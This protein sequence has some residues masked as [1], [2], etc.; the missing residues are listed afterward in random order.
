MFSVQ[1][2]RVDELPSGKYLQGACNIIYNLWHFLV[3]LD[4]WYLLSLHLQYLWVSELLDV[5]CI[6][7]F[8]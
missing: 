3:Q 5:A 7:L 4:L 1:I 6:N 8:H 2:I